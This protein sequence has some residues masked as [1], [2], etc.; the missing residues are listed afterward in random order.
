M[1]IT[2]PQSHGALAEKKTYKYDINNVRAE[3]RKGTHGRSAHICALESPSE[4]EREKDSERE[5]DRFSV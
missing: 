1:R 3:G 2:V 5:T 4:L